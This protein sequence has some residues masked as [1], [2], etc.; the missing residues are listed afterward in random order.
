MKVGGCGRGWWLRTG[1]VVITARF[2]WPGGPCDWPYAARLLLSLFI[3][4]SVTVN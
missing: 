3:A 2:I 4:L 1:V